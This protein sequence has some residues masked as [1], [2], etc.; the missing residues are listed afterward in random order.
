ML[1][2]K[3]ETAVVVSTLADV[4]GARA[5][6]AFHTRRCYRY[7]QDDQRFLSSVKDT[8]WLLSAQC[9]GLQFEW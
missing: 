1:D 7:D 8:V 3:P 9:C 4:K 6:G 5:N 2:A